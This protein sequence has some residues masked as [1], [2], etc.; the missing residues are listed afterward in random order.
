MRTIAILTVLLSC[1]LIL[2]AACS[3]GQNEGMAFYLTRDDVPPAQMS[4]LSQVQLADQPLIAMP[5]IVYYNLQTHALKLTA[6]A[7][8]RLVQLQVPVSGKSFVV[9]LDHAAVYWGAFWTPIS[10]QSFDGITIWKPFVPR[11]S[12]IVFLEMGYPSEAFYQGQ[13]PRNNPEI[14]KAL[15]KSNQLVDRFDIEEIDRLPAA[16]KGYELYSWQQDGQW[17]FTLIGGTNRNKTRAEILTSKSSISESGVVVVYATGVNE[18][19]TVLSRISSGQS[20][21]WMIGPRPTDPADQIEFQLPPVEIVSE[22]KE[23]A[24][25]CGLQMFP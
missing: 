23:Y 21:G 8:E 17:Q 15:E 16:F 12:H 14:L 2:P 4:D 1:L 5:D 19:K 11:E 24:Q 25:Q 9:C 22:I 7:Y 6:G 20:I 10:S 18:L 3:S 13:D